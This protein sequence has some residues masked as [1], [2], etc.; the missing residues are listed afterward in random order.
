MLPEQF[1]PLLEDRQKPRGT[2][3]A[4]LVAKNEVS[5][6]FAVINADDFYGRDAYQQIAQFLK[7]SNSND[8]GLV[9]YVLKNTI[10]PF[11]SVNRGACKVDNGDLVSIYEHLKIISNGDVFKDKD[12]LVVFPDAIVSMNF[13]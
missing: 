2:A 12:E 13:R 11:G 7:T 10:S 8:M 1:T 6:P 5:T 3:H 4:M 9:G